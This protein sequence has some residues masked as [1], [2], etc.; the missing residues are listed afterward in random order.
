MI[1]TLPVVFICAVAPAALADT[2]TYVF[3][4]VSNPSL[5]LGLITFSDPSVTA[6]ASW[7][8]VGSA[9]VPGPFVTN[10]SFDLTSVGG[11][12]I[13][14]ADVAAGST[15]SSINSNG[16]ELIGSGD[17]DD[18]HI[19]TTFGPDLWSSVD[20]GP[21]TDFMYWD[22]SSGP[23][24]QGDWVVIPSPSSMGLFGVLGAVATRARRG[25]H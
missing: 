24:I 4:P 18:F 12:V 13:T 23:S 22:P 25:E 11:P 14:L 1:R 5:Q 16:P 8:L 6:A 3:R 19:N 17:P 20:F 10:F 21:A 2:V 9:A 15:V 7:N